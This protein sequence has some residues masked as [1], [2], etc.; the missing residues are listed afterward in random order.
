MS[1]NGDDI[2]AAQNENQQEQPQPLEAAR[3]ALRPPAVFKENISLW[4]GIAEAHFDSANIT[5]DCTKYGC[6]VTALDYDTLS[7]VSDIVT[8]PNAAN[9]YQKLKEALLERLGDSLERR[10]ARLLT[11]FEPGDK[12]P[13][14]LLRQMQELAGPQQKDSQIVKTLWTQRLP[15]HAQAIL[16]SIPDPTLQ[17]LALTADQLM[18]VYHNIEVNSVNQQTLPHPKTTPDPLLLEMTNHVK[19]QQRLLIDLAREVHQLKLRNPSQQQ[20]PTYNRSRS[21]NRTM[22]THSGG[23]SHTRGQSTTKGELCY[24][25]HKFGNLAQ[26]C[27]APCKYQNKENENGDSQK[28][29]T[30][31]P[32]PKNAD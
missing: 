20:N 11:G 9:K 27:Q 5:R 25:H 3:I 30:E 21:Q 26:K 12:K 15:K 16:K 10:T 4:I 28:R 29:Q 1:V 31:R 7:F 2:P 13:S 6:L 14:H 23:R 32:V 18:E 24:F 8:G 17:Q 19:S 22:N